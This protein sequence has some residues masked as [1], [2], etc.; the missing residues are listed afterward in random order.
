MN[1]TVE[2]SIKI[3]AP[4][5]KVFDFTQDWSKRAQWDHTVVSFV[6]L[7]G[8]ERGYRVKASGGLRFVVRYKLYRAPERTSLAISEINWPMFTGGGGSWEYAA[9]GAGTVFTQRNTLSMPDTM[10]ARLC[11]PLLKL[12]LS[13]DARKAMAKAKEI[14]ERQ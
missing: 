6:T 14:L 10:L 5:R 13:S 8:P 9:D 12:Q 4:P 11:A 1:V 2:E 7:D 3:E